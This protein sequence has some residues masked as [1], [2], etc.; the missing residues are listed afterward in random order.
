MADS[1]PILSIYNRHS[2]PGPREFDTSTGFWSYFMNEYG[3]QWV[4]AMD[5]DSGV[6]F[7]CSG[8]I[9]WESRQVGEDG[10]KDLVLNL[11]ERMW[12]LACLHACKLIEVAERVVEAWQEFDEKLRG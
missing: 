9:G 5:R 1:K 7:L 3:E 2:E 11:P 12:V 6:F 10:L 8:D 4:F